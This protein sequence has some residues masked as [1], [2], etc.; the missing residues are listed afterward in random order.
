MDSECV[1][2][3]STVGIPIVRDW[4]LVHIV[5]AGN[6][7][8]VH[9]HVRELVHIVRVGKAALHMGKELDLEQ[10]DFSVSFDH[11]QCA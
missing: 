11:V 4:E 6:L 8:I 7:Y 10:I 9:V 2:I 5:R 3:I 1:F